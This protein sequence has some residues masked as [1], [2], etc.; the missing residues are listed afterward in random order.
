MALLLSLL[1]TSSDGSI[2]GISTLIYLIEKAKDATLLSGA[3]ARERQRWL[4]RPKMA[5]LLLHL[6][7]L[8]MDPP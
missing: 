8:V 4:E 7:H 3:S 1:D 6:T 2:T 5:L